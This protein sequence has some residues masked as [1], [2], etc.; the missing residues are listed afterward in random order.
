MTDP[1][2]TVF[3]V[4]DDL[5]VRRSTGRLV[6]SAESLRADFPATAELFTKSPITSPHFSAR[7]SRVTSGA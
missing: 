5:S 3:I 4:D 6:H 7:I 2:P 1:D